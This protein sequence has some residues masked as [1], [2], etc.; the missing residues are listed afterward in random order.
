MMT[1]TVLAIIESDTIPAA[2]LSKVMNERLRRFAAELQDKH[3]KDLDLLDP[4]CEDVVIYLGYDSKYNVRWKIVNDV[5]A[6]IES[7]VAR[8]CALLG[9]VLWKGSTIYNFNSR[10]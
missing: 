3:L 5:S 8:H 1:V 2:P 7:E 4:D 9:Y 10:N 6:A